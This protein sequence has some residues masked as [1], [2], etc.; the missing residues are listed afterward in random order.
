MTQGETKA[1]VRRASGWKCHR[2][3]KVL[4]EVGLHLDHPALCMRCLDVVTRRKNCVHEMAEA[5]YDAAMRDIEAAGVPRLAAMRA[6]GKL[7]DMGPLG[8]NWR[9]FTE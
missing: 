4:P 5:A 8:F 7:I 2:C 3:W 6:A 1:I 9:G